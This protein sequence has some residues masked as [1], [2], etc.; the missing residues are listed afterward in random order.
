MPPQRTLTAPTNAITR[1]SQYPPPDAPDP[2]YSSTPYTMPNAYPTIP[3]QND[4]SSGASS[5][6][7]GS[8]QQASP[9]SNYHSPNRS[10]Q[11]YTRTI[12]PPVNVPST[13]L[14]NSF[15]NETIFGPSGKPKK[16][17]VACDE[18][19]KKKTKCD[20]QRESSDPEGQASRGPKRGYIQD[21]GSTIT[22][23]ETQIQRQNEFHRAE[24]QSLHTMIQRLEA[25]LQ[26]CHETIER[27]ERLLSTSQNASERDGPRNNGLQRLATA[28][29]EDDG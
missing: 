12:S 14:H 22:R 5:Y 25:Q 3:E 16:S 7:R 8:Y 9:A 28:A 18:C 13:T 26:G 23:L 11:S 15:P 21:M 10:P 1:N 2:A 17:G 29:A 6:P 24:V 4:T 27:H 20:G 19:R